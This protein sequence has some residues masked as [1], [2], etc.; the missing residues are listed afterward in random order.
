[1]ESR[2]N[3][4]ARLET[5]TEPFNV[6]TKAFIRVLFATQISVHW[7]RC[8]KRNPGKA[9]LCPSNA[10]RLIAPKPLL[11]HPSPT[12]QCAESS[13]EDIQQPEPPMNPEAVQGHIFTNPKLC[14]DYILEPK[15]VIPPTTPS[16]RS[17]NEVSLV[18]D[19]RN[20][21]ATTSCGSSHEHSTRILQT[22]TVLPNIGAT[23]HSIAL[24]TKQIARY[25]SIASWRAK[26]NGRTPPSPRLPNLQLRPQNQTVRR[27]NQYHR[28]E[29][30]ETCS[31]PPAEI[32]LPATRPSQESSHSVDQPPSMSNDSP[33]DNQIEDN[34]SHSHNTDPADS[35]ALLYA[36]NRD[37]ALLH[38]Q[39]L[40]YEEKKRFLEELDHGITFQIEVNCRFSI[41]GRVFQNRDRAH[42]TRLQERE[43]GT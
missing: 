3:W 41:I 38:R 4:L 43:S 24:T 20:S 36:L 14:L 19:N 13:M 5:N 15:P 33:M 26:L 1:L 27:M 12:S 28:V 31:V 2:P 40:F 30:V 8:Q 39:H 17:N 9:A 16:Q 10:V 21:E 35:I 7:L 22:E 42:Q 32:R 37:I 25:F 29:A 18:P 6:E 34:A 11:M 23:Q